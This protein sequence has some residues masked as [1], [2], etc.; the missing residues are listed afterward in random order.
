MTMYIEKLMNERHMT[1]ADLCRKSRLPESTLRGILNGDASI[2]HCRISTIAAL[3]NALGTSVEEILRNFRNEH[4]S[5]NRSCGKNESLPKFWKNSRMEDFCLHR[6][7]ILELLHGEGHRNFIR[8][9]R[10]NQFVERMEK[11]GD[12]SIC[13]YTVCLMDY[14]CRIHKLRPFPEYER[15]RG[16]MLEQTVFPLFL[17]SCI[18][19][20]F[21]CRAM[22][23]ALE[24]DAIPEFLRC[25]IFETEENLGMKK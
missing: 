14:L 21:A 4:D 6:V 12:T 17:L 16:I 13:L 8:Y 25:N 23:K 10:E 9:I 22:V 19:D 11:A 2:P 24:R 5:C 7:L 15:Y 3:A 20:P 18:D 1:R